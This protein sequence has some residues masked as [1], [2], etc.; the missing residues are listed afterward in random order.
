M[1]SEEDIQYRV[2]AIMD[3]EL[4]LSPDLASLCDGPP[5]VA[6]AQRADHARVTPSHRHARGQLLG[7]LQG[8]LTVDTNQG[9]WVVPATHA[10][11][12][13]PEM[14]HGLHSHGPFSGW[15]VYVAPGACQELPHAPCTVAVSALLR[16]AIAR[17][18]TWGEQPLEAQ[19]LHIAAVILD[20]IRLLPPEPLGVPMP[21][22]PRLQKIAHALANNPAD[23]RNLEEWA[24][25]AGI[26]PRTLTRRFAAETGFSFTEWRQRIRLLRA[27][28]MLAT[29]Q[30]VTTVALDLG[31]D[32]VSAFITLFRRKLTRAI[33]PW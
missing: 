19:H 22:D 29:G 6:V 25:W 13:P 7:A 12:I 9:R 32:N 5:I 3:Q 1:Y 15:S 20:E 11:W 21:Q 4:L 18:T 30:S 31:Y 16:E 17:A 14:E 26:A 28:E 27:I 10:V 24:S 8:L 23:E 2:K 33:K